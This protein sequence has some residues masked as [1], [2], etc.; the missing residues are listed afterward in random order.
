MQYTTRT[1]GSDDGDL[2]K[3][4][5]AGLIGGLIASWTMNRFQDVWNKVAKGIESRSENQVYN[6]LGEYAGDVEKASG[7]QELEF[8]SEPEVPIHGYA[9][10]S[11]FVY[12]LT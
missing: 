1:N 11:H 12:G 2:W 7:T 5:A 9:L 8:A 10:S 6:G 3:G 4:F